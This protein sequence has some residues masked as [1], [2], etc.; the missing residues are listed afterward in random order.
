[1]A[2]GVGARLRPLTDLTPKPLLQLD[3]TPVL[4]IILTQLRAAGFDHVTLALH[5]RAEQIRAFVGDG[6]WLGLDVEYSVSDQL[7]GT[8]GPLALV[9]RP[10]EPCLVTNADLLTNIAFGDVMH[11]HRHAGVVATMVLCRLAVHIP[12][13]VVRVAPTRTVVGYEEKPTHEVLVNAG[14]YVVEPAAWDKVRPGEYV[15]MS[16][17]IQ[18]GTAAGRPIGTYLH[19]GDWLDIGTPEQY[20]RADDLLRAHRARFLGTG[21]RALE[22]AS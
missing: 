15:D 12:F 21:G 18:R 9:D 6:R 1:M 14:I 3:G 4:E 13:G 11:H 22:E 19:V 10:D 8:A 20:A 17:L 2:G 5:Y 16:T 7:L